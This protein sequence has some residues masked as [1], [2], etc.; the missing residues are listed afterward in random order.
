MYH[1]II[2]SNT[3]SALFTPTEANAGPFYVNPKSA[4]PKICPN[5]INGSGF[6]HLE[7]QEK[8]ENVEHF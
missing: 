8:N 6:Y 3:L 7:F 1:Y 2:S 5:V 4:T